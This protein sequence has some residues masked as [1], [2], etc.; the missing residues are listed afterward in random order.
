MAWIYYK[1]SLKE[2][3]YLIAAD[4]IGEMYFYGLGVEQSYDKALEYM[5]S[6]D[7]F[8]EEETDEISTKA[9]YPLSEMYKNG[10]GVEQDLELAERIFNVAESRDWL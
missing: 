5:K 2:D 3:G 6:F 8:D 1:R 7:E 9:L 10:L 4:R